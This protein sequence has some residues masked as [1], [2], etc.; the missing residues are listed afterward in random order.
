MTFSSEELSVCRRLVAI[1]LEEDLGTR[2]DLTSQAVIPPELLGRAVFTARADGVLAGLPTAT[3]VSEAIDR[4]LNFTALRD[5]GD[6]IHAGDRLATIAGPMR[7]I[8]AVERIALN[9]LQHL[10]GIASL[11]RKYV[12]DV[13]GLPT[14]ILDTRKTIPG[15]RL[16]AKYAVR[17]GGGH[18]HRLGLHDGVLIKDNHLAALG[19]ELESVART[20]K[21]ALATSGRDVPVEVEVESLEQLEVALTCRPAII[22]L[23]N[24]QSEIMRQ[25]VERRNAVAPEV[26]LEAS[27]GVTLETVHTIAETGVDRISIGALTHSA[28][29]LDIALDYEAA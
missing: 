6:R 25:A 1:A 23:D 4:H 20:L 18:N 26:L 9:F 3:M 24:M 2:G 15:W 11:T 28:P 14:K 5:D 22:L 29:A 27:G 13:A 16:L 19:K 8:L 10:S 17:Q 7:S 12:D 21:A